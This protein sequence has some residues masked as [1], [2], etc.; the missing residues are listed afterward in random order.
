MARSADAL[1]DVYE[2]ALKDFR[3]RVDEIF[4]EFAD[5]VLNDQVK[6]T[7]SILVER[8]RSIRDGAVEEAIDALDEATTEPWNEMRDRLEAAEEI[9][10]RVNR[11]LA[12]AVVQGH[13]NGL[14]PER[15]S[16]RR[17]DGRLRRAHY[18]LVRA[19]VE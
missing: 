19:G 18:D 4:Q 13:D 9:P 16:E 3:A 14:R 10:R 17:D 7:R 8:I 5:W 1:A 12:L 2:N 11:P 15:A 6:V